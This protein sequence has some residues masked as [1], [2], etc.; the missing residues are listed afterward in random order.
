MT[1]KMIYTSGLTV[2]GAIL[3]SPECATVGSL[4]STKE[5]VANAL[6]SI[7]RR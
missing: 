4:R 2:I 5:P 6:R 1:R 3:G 7:R